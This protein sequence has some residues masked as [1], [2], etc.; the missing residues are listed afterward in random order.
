MYP[1]VPS[2]AALGSQ[3]SAIKVPE[4]AIAGLT[5]Y[6]AVLTLIVM[7]LHW[8]EKRQTLVE[9][10]IEMQ[11]TSGTQ[12]HINIVLSSQADQITG[13]RDIDTMTLASI[14]PSR[15][16]LLEGRRDACM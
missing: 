11:A 15:F 4:I 7:L 1:V 12:V 2:Q 14:P 5:L 16:G 9:Q 8:W 3:P 10:D 13:E 6:V